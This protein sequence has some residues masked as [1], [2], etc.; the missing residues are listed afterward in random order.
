MANLAVEYHDHLNPLIWN[1]D[2]LKPE[3]LE[4]LR[5]VAK[6][7]IEW[8]DA[9]EMKIKD[10]VFVGSNVNYNWDSDSDIDLHILIDLK[11]FQTDCHDF[12][13]D[14]FDVKNK[15]FKE[16]F[17]IKLYGKSVEVTVEDETHHFVSGGIYSVTKGK[18]VRE[19]KYDPPEYDKEKAQAISDKWKKKMVA[20]M[21]DPSATYD[22]MEGLRDKLK[23]YRSARLK[24]GGEFDVGN[25]AFKDLRRRGYVERLKKKAQQALTKE[26]SLK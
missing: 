21:K 17:P 19:P 9:P 23:D 16:V 11:K 20:K 12:A 15:R 10:I 22:E 4:H 14:F 26:L 25:V 18:W 5:M 8:C 6:K 2:R 13:H 3:V 24:K 7:F 1:G